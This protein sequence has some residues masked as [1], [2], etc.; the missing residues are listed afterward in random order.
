MP[1]A[2]QHYVITFL[3][4]MVTIAHYRF[5]FFFFISIGHNLRTLLLRPTGRSRPT[6]WTTLT[7]STVAVIVLF[8]FHLWLTASCVLYSCTT[9][10]VSMMT[11]YRFFFFHDTGHFCSVKVTED[12][13]EMVL[14][15][16]TTGVKEGRHLIPRD[17]PERRR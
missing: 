3:Q 7:Y 12:Q 16:I 5:I 4:Y 15:F 10:V 13:I 2:L 1:V 17:S 6:Y 8:S 14:K 9:F 11:T